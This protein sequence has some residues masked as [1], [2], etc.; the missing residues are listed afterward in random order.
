MEIR[1]LKPEETR[2]ADILD[3][4]SFVI[5]LKEGDRKETGYACD[6]W[7][8]FTDGGE[9][10]ACLDNHDLPIWFDGGVAPA[11]GVGSVA[12]DPI[13]RG[14]GHIRA[15]M[16][17]VLNDDRAN[18]A[19]FSVLYPFSHPFYRKFGYETCYASQKVKFPTDALELFRAADPPGIRMIRPDDG[20][21]ALFPIYT[22]FSKQYN[23][24][25]ARDER[26]WRR[27]KLG[28]PLKTEQYCY[29]LTREG[30]DD[31]Y[32]VFHFRAG[33]KPYFRTLCLTDY[34]FVNVRAFH[35]LM[36]FL[37]RY[38]A[39]AQDVELTVPDDLPLAP[40]LPEIYA[41]NRFPGPIPMARVLHAE[42]VL[43]AMGHPQGNGAYRVYVEDAF[44]P[45]NE[46]CYQVKFADGKASAARCECKPDLRLS[47]QTLAQLS[48]G[49]LS[50]REAEFKHD[51]R[52]LD[53]EETLRA[54]FIKKPVFL[55]DL[56]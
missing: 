29:V 48:L 11:R 19:M 41:A 7:G 17:R 23:L 56:Y 51:V 30:R 13:S 49:F 55:W 24:A 4:L 3:S 2:A 35:D 52:I 15:L 21:N 5:P 18:G 27:I 12:S 22:E 28:D 25:V 44:L 8:C 37:Y 38:A 39:Q 6:R 46:G 9:L 31:A 16:E 14:E 36:G 54:V 20:L 33:E 42:R 40:L 50:L 47:V 53:N 10:S 26:T 34:A 43:A 32:A 1:K 45:D